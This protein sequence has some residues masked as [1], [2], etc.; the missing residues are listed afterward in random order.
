M[1]NKNGSTLMIVM[2]VFT[3]FALLATGL[4]ILFFMNLRIRINTIKER[5]SMIELTND[6]YRYLN[7]NS[8]VTLVGGNFEFEEYLIEVIILED[9]YKIIFQNSEKEKI[10]AEI[11]VKYQDENY[12]IISWR[13][14]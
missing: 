11:I 3:L 7:E 1:K 8:K 14:G 5:A 13:N 4:S 9:K 2:L 6:F 10:K 12:E